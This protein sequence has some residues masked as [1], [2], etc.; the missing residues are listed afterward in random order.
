MAMWRLFKD[1]PAD[2]SSPPNPH[3]LSSGCYYSSSY[4]EITSS[5]CSCFSDLHT[6]D[7]DV[8]RRSGSSPSRGSS[9]FRTCEGSSGFRGCEGG[10]YR[11]GLEQ[12]SES[13]E[14]AGYRCWKVD[15]ERS[16]VRGHM[17]AVDRTETRKVR[18]R[19]RRKGSSGRFEKRI[20][21]NEASGWDSRLPERCRSAE[22]LRVPG[23]WNTES[24]SEPVIL[25]TKSLAQPLGV[26][27]EPPGWSSKFP[28]GPSC[29]TKSS[30][31]IPD[32]PSL[33]PDL[34]GKVL[35]PDR[36]SASTEVPEQI[37]CIFIIPG[38]GG[39]RG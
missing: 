6:S 8:F 27:T 3:I 23:C 25:T 9:G 12:Q 4:T 34:P 2:L 21:L 38:G 17:S 20:S 13:D 26:T 10:R 39:R 18:R 37:H 11:P 29:A 19:K 35:S 32:S 36:R 22:E 1:S 16:D 28:A 15:C 31:D 24:L 33:L 7:D 14:L 30:A 5:S